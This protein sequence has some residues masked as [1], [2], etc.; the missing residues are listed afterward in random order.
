MN[1]DDH[2]LVGFTVEGS[3][4]RLGYGYI[5]LDDNG[6]L[7][8]ARSKQDAIAGKTSVAH[9]LDLSLL[10]EL[11]SSAPGAREFRYLQPLSED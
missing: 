3:T 11:P 8:V 2:P 10:E 7:R 4:L 9:S 1:F 5:F 6:F